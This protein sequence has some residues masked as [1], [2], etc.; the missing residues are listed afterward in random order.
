IIVLFGSEYINKQ[1][2]CMCCLVVIG[3]TTALN[4]SVGTIGL[5]F[6]INAINGLSC[7][8]LDVLM[9]VWVV[10]MWEQDCGPYIQA[11]HFTAS[12]AAF[13]APLIA[14]PFLANVSSLYIPFTIIGV[15]ISISGLY[16]G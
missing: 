8:V 9:S 14:K 2:G 12:I 10:E 5:L 11:L 7:G 1:I 16:L 3:I 13:F 15:L 6:L 4:V